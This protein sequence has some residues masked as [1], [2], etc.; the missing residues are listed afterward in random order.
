MSLRR[1]ASVGLPP[2][3]RDTTLLRDLAASFQSRNLLLAAG[4]TAPVRMVFVCT[5]ARVTD[6]AVRQR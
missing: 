5:G 4:L 6:G 1:C 2:A 3:A